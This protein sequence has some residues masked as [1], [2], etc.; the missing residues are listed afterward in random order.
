MK[1]S[2]WV[3]NALCYFQEIVGDEE[4]FSEYLL[5]L[6]SAVLTNGSP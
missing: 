5:F 3:P 4:Y 2:G 6:L 1:V